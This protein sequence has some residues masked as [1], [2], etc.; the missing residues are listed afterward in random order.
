MKPTSPTS[1]VSETR[2]AKD[3]GA[4]AVVT[5]L[6]P[7]VRWGEPEL[8][9]LTEMIRQPSLF[10][11]NGPQTRL[12]VERFRTIF[13]LRHAMPCSSGTAAIHIAVHAA[14]VGP[15][16]EV[17]TSP[18]TDMGTVIG[19]LYQQ[20]VPVF[21]DLESDRYNLDPAD[22][23]RKITPRTKAILAVHLAGNPC[24][25]H[26]LREIADEH[27]LVLIEDCAQAWGARF[28]GRPV[29]TVGDLGCWSLNDFKHIGAG[30]GGIVATN[31]EKF[32]SLLQR[33]G[34][35]A[36]D[37][38]K[39]TRAPEFLAPNYR[40]SEPQ[41]AVAAAQ[42]LR[43][44]EIAAARNRLG[45]R[46]AEKLAEIPG[47]RPPRVAKGDFCS[48]WFFMLRMDPSAFR[49]DRAEFVEALKAEGAA[50]GAGYIPTP[51]YR[52][53]VFQNHNFFAGRWPVKE[54]GLTAIDYRTTRC[55]EAEAI[56]ETA[57]LCPLNQGMDETF[58]RETAEAFHKVATHYRK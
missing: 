46:L 42:M 37:R 7:L 48:F 52:Y 26:R 35:K 19:I 31:S 16:D 17:I 12:L 57:I 22:V 50:A 32:G 23:R 33:C 54:L 36:Y 41:S 47:L 29:G 18:I 24:D 14:G 2:L 44:E 43:M 10:Y 40:I 1:C 58:I 53:P 49:C 11:W 25:L 21:A 38:V 34:D 8:Q 51:L 27:R 5:K 55:P 56:L 20:G 13:P 30:D 6:A 39:Q 45:M 4:P 28:A 3:G 15:G 9:Q